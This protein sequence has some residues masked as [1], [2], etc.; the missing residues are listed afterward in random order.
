MDEKQWLTAEDWQPMFLYLS[1]RQ[2]QR[3]RSLYFCAGLRCDNAD[4]LSHLCGL[5][6]H[7]RACWAVDALLEKK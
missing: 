6:P 3:K 2:S 4:I 5:G 7:A 1:G